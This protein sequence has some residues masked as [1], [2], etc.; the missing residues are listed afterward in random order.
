MVL[1]IDVYGCRVGL[2]CISF[3]TN[4]VEQ[5]FTFLLITN[6][7]SFVKYLF[8]SVACIFI[9]ILVIKLQEFF[10]TLYMSL[11]QLYAF[12][13]ISFQSLACLFI[14]LMKSFKEQKF[15]HFD[16]VLFISFLL[17][18]LVLCPI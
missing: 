6:I 17:H 5:L 12:L 13:N 3:M 14:F 8:K 16:E 10:S 9:S 18:F 11:C 1:L 2:V 4:D 15:E 7:P